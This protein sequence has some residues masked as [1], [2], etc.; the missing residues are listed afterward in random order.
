MATA[1][2]ARS[3]MKERLGRAWYRH[4][5]IAFVRHRRIFTFY[6]QLHALIRA[7][8]PLPTGFAQLQQ[9]APDA[10]MAQGL[11]RVAAAVRGGST[12]G[13]A[14]RA[15]SALFDDANVE[16]LAFAE[17]AG[18][19]EPVSASLLLHLERVQAQRW[20]AVMGALWPLYLL[21]AFVFVGPLLEV[22]QQVTS[23]SSVGALYAANLARS[24]FSAAG[25]LFAVLGAPFVI[26]ALD[27]DVPWDRFKRQVPLLGAPMRPLA[28]SRF[29]LGLGLS[30]ASGVEV[31]RALRISAKATVSPSVIADLP[32]AEARLR[33]GGTLV[34]AVGVLNVIDRST[35]G[36]LAVAETTGTLDST[37]ERLSKELEESS[38]RALRFLALAVTAV[39]AGVLLVKLVASM[40]STLLGPVT[41]LYDAAGSGSLD[42]S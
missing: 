28:A 36:T 22:S 15:S 38:L 4:P 39:I 29:V 14:L 20:K 6:Q 42:R 31:V 17:E 11:G 7:G 41:K 3:T 9:Y 12:L 32:L 18:R 37:L 21:G 25:V 30:M 10:A 24:L 16:L 2:R 33:A 5:V 13:D 23:S 26:A 19:L 34:D 40:L 1:E 27:V 8:V 35:L